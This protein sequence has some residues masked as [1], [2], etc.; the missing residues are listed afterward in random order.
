ME[1]TESKIRKIIKESLLQEDFFSSDVEDVGTITI[2][3]KGAK[4][5][6]SKKDIAEIQKTGKTLDD[7]LAD[8]VMNM[9]RY[10]PQKAQIN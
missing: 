3:I 10:G 6:L 5:N 7:V 4:R 9:V 8:E 2:K 1:I